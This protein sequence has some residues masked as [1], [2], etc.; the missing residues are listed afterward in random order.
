M[1]SGTGKYEFILIKLK[2]T[3]GIQWIFVGSCTAIENIRPDLSLFL[4][5]LASFL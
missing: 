4:E 2:L 5:L 3:N 1:L